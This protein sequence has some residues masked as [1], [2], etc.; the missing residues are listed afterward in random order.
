MFG[1]ERSLVQHF[2][3]RPFALLGVNGD[4]SP[5]TLRQAQQRANHTW[6]SWWDGPGGRITAAWRVDRY[7]AFFLI[8]ARGAVRW[9][10]VGAPA[11]QELQD[12]IEGLLKE[13]E[14]APTS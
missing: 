4:E 9:Q 11:P 2:A 12:R 13:A 5:E 6:P 1:H 7:P 3:G 14:K 10:Y 8:D